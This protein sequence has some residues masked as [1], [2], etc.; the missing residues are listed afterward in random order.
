MPKT[1]RNAPRRRT[2]LSL[3]KSY[4]AILT[5]MKHLI[6]EARRRSISMVNRE[7]VFLYWAIGRTIVAQQEQRAW[8][9]AVVE[10]LSADLRT[11]FPDMRGLSIQNLWKMR[12]FFLTYRRISQ[13]QQSAILSTASR[14]LAASDS[15]EILSTLSRELS[16][17]DLASAVLAVSWSHHALICSASEE[18]AQQYFYLQTAVKERWSVRELERQ[19]ESDLF[20][21][22]MSVNREP[23]KCL[24]AVAEQGALLPFKDHYILDFLGLEEHH[25]ERQLRKAMLANVRDLFLEFGREFALVGEEH[26]VTVGD[27]TFRIDLLLFHRRLQCLVALELKTGELKPEHVGK[28]QFYLA[29]LDEYVRLPH[30]K[31]SIG[32]ILCKSARGLRM[33]L[34]LTLAA[35]RV[36]VATYQTALP[37]ESLILKRLGEVSA[38]GPSRP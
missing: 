4:E 8:G 36:G 16:S 15:P 34:A 20:S 25:S 26:P 21:R 11:A 7:L 14:E 18:P 33:K 5:E 22:Y 12:H 38:P 10:R 13:W 9:D 27:E 37:D 1:S 32:L 19:I 6:S 35:R 17:P 3:P 31:P 30:E 2:R 29:A 23:E 24:S 28:C